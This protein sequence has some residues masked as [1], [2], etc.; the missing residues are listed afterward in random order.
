[1]RSQLLLLDGYYFCYLPARFMS[2][3][4][5]RWNFS[6]EKNP[7]VATSTC[8]KAKPICCVDYLGEGGFWCVQH[9]KLMCQ[10]T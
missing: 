7:Q 10:G 2:R 4:I 8:L 3:E 9:L 6:Y 5:A 1:M